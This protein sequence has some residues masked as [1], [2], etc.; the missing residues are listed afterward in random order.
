MKKEEDELDF[1]DQKSIYVL[2][3]LEYRLD[4]WETKELSILMTILRGHHNLEKYQ[5]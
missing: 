5:T 3:S 2:I 1:P 4:F